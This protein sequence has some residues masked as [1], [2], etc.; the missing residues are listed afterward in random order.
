[1]KSYLIIGDGRVAK[2][3]SHYFSLLNIPH[4]N[5]SRGSCTEDELIQLSKQHQN[6]LVLISDSQID[7]FI[8][9]HPCLQNK[10]LIHFSGSL[11]SAWASMAHP[12]MTFS[13]E[14][15]ELDEY[16]QISFIAANN[17][18]PLSELIPELPNRTYSLDPEKVP[19]YH[20]L[21]VMSGNF[22]NILW[23]ST[24]SIF[25]DELKLPAHVLQNYL[26]KT[27]DNLNAAMEMNTQ[28]TP[29]NTLTGPI[30][31]GDVTTIVKNLDALTHRPEQNLYYAFLN[32]YLQNHKKMGALNYE[33]LTV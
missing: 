7:P 5:W 26:Q 22:T 12:L 28:N 33:R 15:Y 4:T 21:C 14:L 23:Q 9:S 19:L 10:K 17:S 32:Y 13:N 25:R 31:R 30:A 20:A 1:M 3:F 11:N 29:K 24:I 27:A 18:L 2:H 16:K 8:E 6:A